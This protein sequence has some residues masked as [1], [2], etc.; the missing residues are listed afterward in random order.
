MTTRLVTEIIEEL[1]AEVVT[2]APKPMEWSR[3]KAQL[4]KGSISR[5]TLCVGALEFDVTQRDVLLLT[6]VEEVNE[7]LRRLNICGF[8]DV[9][10]VNVMH[11]CKTHLPALISAVAPK[12]I[13]AHDTAAF[14]L[15]FDYP[16]DHL[17]GRTA[18][19]WANDVNN[20]G[21]FVLFMLPARPG[22]KSWWLSQLYKVD[23]Y[24]TGE[25]SAWDEI[26]KGLCMGENKVNPARECPRHVVWLDQNGLP[27]CKGHKTLPEKPKT[28]A[29]RRERVR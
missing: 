8:D 12:I 24:L 10:V 15:G 14:S 21:C 2:Q 22:N 17:A 5:C 11:F 29:R 26:G 19:W 18:I 6:H 4:L 23:R 20:L 9:M 7:A 25:Q 16:M 28:K 27:F 13:L 1:G 3:D